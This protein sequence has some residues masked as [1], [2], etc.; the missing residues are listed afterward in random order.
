MNEEE[1]RKGQRCASTA[2]GMSL[3]PDWELRHCM[4]HGTPVR[5]GSIA[6]SMRD[7]RSA[8]GGGCVS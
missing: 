7:L 2:E 1:V 3:S 4:L 8:G 5:R 6:Q